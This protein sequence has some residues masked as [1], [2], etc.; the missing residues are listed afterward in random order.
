MKKFI[1]SLFLIFSFAASTFA[2]SYKDASLKDKPIV[3][4]VT[5]QGCGACREFEPFFKKTQAKFASKYNF[6]KEDVYTSDIARKLNVQETPS[7]FILQPKQKTFQKIKWECLCQQGCF[8][9]TLK[10]YQKK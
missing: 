8:E 3:L 9:K 2:M 1:F 5:M 4:F 6:V 10:D 7:V